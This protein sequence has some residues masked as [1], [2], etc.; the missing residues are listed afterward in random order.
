MAGELGVDEVAPEA[1]TERAAA[2]VHVLELT[3]VPLGM[4][5]FERWAN[6]RHKGVTRQAPSLREGRP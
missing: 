5:L 3:L 2:A 1:V 4:G 6:N